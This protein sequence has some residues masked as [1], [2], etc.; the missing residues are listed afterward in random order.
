MK[1]RVFFWNAVILTVSSV[2]MR[3]FN[4]WFRSL[5]TG[6]IDASG[7]G[8]Y[9]LIFSVFSLGIILS[10]SGIGFAVTRLVAEGCGSRR[11]VRLCLCC[12]LT[13]SFAAA[14]VIFTYADFIAVSWIQDAAA[15]LP[16]RLLAPGLPFIAVCSCLRGYF[17]AIRNTVVPVLCDF[18]EQIATIGGAL[19]LLSRMKSLDAIML[20]ST[21]GEI[22]SCAFI[23]L[24]YLWF[25]KKNRFPRRYGQPLFRRVVHIAAPVL[26]GSVLRGTLS[27]VENTLIPRG[28]KANGANA[29]DSFAQ[30]G[31]MQGMVMPILFFPSAFLI[32]LSTLMVPELAEANAGGKTEIIKAAAARVIRFTLIFSFLVTTLLIVFADD[33]G[34]AFY[35]NRQAGD[36]LRIMAPI[37]PLL[38]LDS[39]VDGMLKGLDQQF[40]SMTYNFGDSIIRVILIGTT[41]PIFGIKA[42]I[43]ILFFSEIFNASLSINR[44]LK[45]TALEVDIVDWIVTPALASALLYYILILIQK[46][47]CT[48]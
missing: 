30:Y 27:S 7:M 33:L 44:L 40:Y 38:Y 18:L 1:N 41:I 36:M 4:I 26:G 42:Y 39:V 35:R 6:L 17:I 15:A 12:S 10:T 46:L 3:L 43:A 8:L 28:L 32:S 13:L 29:Q 24:M 48:V 47:L 16:L 37:V 9:Q 25:V 20:G 34:M 19:L 31:V 14:F 11:A 21:L 22:V 45:V 5:I 23:G 2:I